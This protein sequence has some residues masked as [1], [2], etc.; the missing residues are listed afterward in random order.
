[1]STIG[2]ANDNGDGMYVPKNLPTS[3]AGPLTE[4]GPDTPNVYYVDFESA[5]V[6]AI[7]SALSSFKCKFFPFQF[8]I[9]NLFF[10]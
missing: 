2:I 5:E 3:L 10:P 6:Q 9:V 1:M 4:L 7:D 8:K